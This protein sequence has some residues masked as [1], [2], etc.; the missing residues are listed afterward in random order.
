MSRLLSVSYYKPDGTETNVCINI[1]NVTFVEMD[2]NEDA[3]D[4]TGIKGKVMVH[5][6]SGEVLNL[7]V[8]DVDSATNLLHEFIISV[9]NNYKYIDISNG[10]V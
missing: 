5:M 9:N 6:T 3:Q 7:F 8:K 4:G 10:K 1:K 2:V